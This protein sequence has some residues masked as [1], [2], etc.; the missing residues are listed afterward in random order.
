[1]RILVVTTWFPSDERPGEAPFNLEHVRAI[2]LK[3]DVRVIHLSL[4][5]AASP[6]NE[7][8][9]GVRVRRL[10]FSPR[11]PVGMLRAWREIRRAARSAD[12]MHTMAFSSA[13]VAAPAHAFS[14]RPWVH[15]EHWNG[16]S[17]PASVG[18]LWPR[19]A[20]LRHVLRLPHRLTGVTSQLTAV[21]ARFGR[22]GAASVVPCVVENTAPITPARFGERLELVA[23][24]ALIPRKQP[25][26]A[27][28][29]LRWLQAN[30]RPVHLTWVGGGEL[31]AAAK[32]LAAELG[33]GGALTLV[34]NLP[35]REVFA[36]IAKADLF[37]LPTA[38]E[39][40]FTSAAEALST[41]RAVVVPLVGGYDDYVDESNSVIVRENSPEA[42]GRGVLAAEARFAA[43][44]PHTLADPIRDRFSLATVGAQFDSI[45]DDVTGRRGRSADR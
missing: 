10:P 2:A 20:W 11:H 4:S 32:E 3:H 15:T 14:R 39:N 26:M 23:V 31:A 42:Y 41:G 29:T 1:M 37:F 18:G 21:L 43:R 27:V 17:N 30:S 33:V 6:S 8:Y 38:Q 25:L 44:D 34:G 12:V 22:P 5:G 13:L 19:L 9:Q 28:E 36:A 45:Y 7:I 24:G 35:P 16:V 40:F